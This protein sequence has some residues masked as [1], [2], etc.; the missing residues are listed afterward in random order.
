M[1]ILGIASGAL[2]ALITLTLTPLVRASALRVGFVDKPGPRKIHHEPMAYGGGIAVALG[3]ATSTAAMLWGWREILHNV[4]WVE[5]KN[6]LGIGLYATQVKMTSNPSLLPLLPVCAAGALGALVLG[7]VDDKVALSPGA[8]LAGQF[9]LAIA[10]VAGGVRI[11]ALVGDNLLMQSATVLWI[12][13]I[14]NSFN[15]LDNM[16]GLCSGTVTISAAVLGL[17][18]MQAGQA[19]LALAL[20]ALSG[21]CLGFLRW[22]MAPAKIFLGDAGSMFVGFLLATLS[23]V[24][25]YFH[26]HESALSVGV[27]FLILAIPLYDT[28]SVMFIRLRERRNLLKGDTSHFSHR[29]VDLGMTHR[30]AVATI[31]LAAL[32]IALPAAVISRLSTAEGLLL[33]GQAVLIL[34]LIALLERA[35]RLKRGE[36]DPSGHGHA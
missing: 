17:L 30:Q 26:Y 4:N 13:L 8:K 28:A 33:V 34:T 24:T 29:L 32:A 5:W 35:G 9:V 16:D 2:A 1:E 6:W 21:A 7:I 14:T 18:A 19:P 25:T 15:L 36:T 10:V 23:V 22:N 31:H 3:M 11:T 20:C 27:P 12:V